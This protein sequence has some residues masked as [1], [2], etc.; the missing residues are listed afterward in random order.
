MTCPVCSPLWTIPYVGT[1]FLFNIRHVFE[2]N[3]RH[4]GAMDLTVR[5][6]GEPEITLKRRS[7]Q[8]YG[9]ISLFPLV[10]TL[11]PSALNNTFRNYRVRDSLQNEARNEQSWLVINPGCSH[12]A[13]CLRFR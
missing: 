4:R 13:R 11:L 7:V 3:F 2:N 9:E 6:C 5:L 10:E 12:A 1:E 8:S